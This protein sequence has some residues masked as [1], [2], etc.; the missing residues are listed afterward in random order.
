MIS[1]EVMEAHRHSLGRREEVQRV[2]NGLILLLQENR[3]MF[4]QDI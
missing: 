4:R 1:G 3:L 2:G